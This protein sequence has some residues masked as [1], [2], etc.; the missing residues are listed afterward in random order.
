MAKNSLKSSQLR[1][2]RL[3]FPPDLTK[4]RKERKV[5]LPDELFKA[6]DSFR[7]QTWLWENYLP[8]LKDAILK[9]GW[10]THQLI[11]TFDPRRLYYRVEH[12][13]NT[14]WCNGSTRDFGSLCPGSN[15]GRVADR[16]AARTTAC[17]SLRSSG[18]EANKQF[19]A[20][21]NPT[22]RIPNLKSPQR[23]A[24]RGRHTEDH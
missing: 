17:G 2:G 1:G 15:P 10:P 9:R 8:G 19:Q 13:L 3:V 20:I 7:G 24:R 4:G 21:V 5:P 18:G 14:R 12:G 6:L 11:M 22:Q 16:I 23:L